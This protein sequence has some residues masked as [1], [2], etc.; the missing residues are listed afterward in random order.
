MIYFSKFLKIS[1]DFDSNS[2]DFVFVL[3]VISI[4]D[5]ENSIF[6][7]VDGGKERV[8]MRMKMTICKISI[9]VLNY[10][11]KITF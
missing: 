7:E 8:R 9:S 6:E 1:C 5:S 2:F 10:L 3:A 4:L 11:G